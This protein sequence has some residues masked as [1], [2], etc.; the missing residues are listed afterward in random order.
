MKHRTPEP[1][2]AQIK[3]EQPVNFG[4]PKLS[5]IYFVTDVTVDFQ[6]ISKFQGDIEL[7]DSGVSFLDGKGVKYFVPMS[8]IRSAIV[9]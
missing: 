8:N 3:Q 2:I 5:L 7:V 4:K 9:K 1:V 6:I